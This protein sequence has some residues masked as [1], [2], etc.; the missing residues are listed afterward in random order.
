MDFLTGSGIEP[1]NGEQLSRTR[2]VRP[3]TE[4]DSITAAAS[5]LLCFFEFFGECGD[6]FEEVADDA[7]V[8]YFED[9]RVG[10]FVDRY[11][12]ARAL[13]AHNVLDR[14]AD[15]QREIQF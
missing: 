3:P 5:G 2:H 6:D 12:G 9:G 14:A 8:G 11:D 10:V 4:A 15:S 1:R 13:H 7:V